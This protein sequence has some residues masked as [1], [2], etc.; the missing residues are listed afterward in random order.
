MV[1]TRCD[2]LLELCLLFLHCV[3][4]IIVI[5]VRVDRAVASPLHH[6]VHGRQHAA[7]GP[8][9]TSCS[10]NDQ[11]RSVVFAGWRRLYVTER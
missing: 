1:S 6:R 7:S 2:S 5:I 11:D 9:Y 3:T 4:F 8:R 10:V